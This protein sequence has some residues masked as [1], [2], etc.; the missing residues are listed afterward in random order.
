MKR[1]TAQCAFVFQRLY[2]VLSWGNESRNG[3]PM[4]FRSYGG[5]T[6]GTIYDDE[7]DF[8][9]AFA[10]KFPG[11]TDDTQNAAARLRR[12]LK[13]LADDG[14]LDRK[15]RPN[16]KEYLGEGGNWS[17]EYSLPQQLAMKIRDGKTTAEEM[18]RRYQGDSELLK[19][20]N[21]WYSGAQVSE[22]EGRR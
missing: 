17:Y 22:M 15:V 7:L 19:D 16:Y 3:G 21:R 1:R 12:L 18:A 14:W 4:V 10:E 2:D 13:Q 20:A 6:C 8:I 9:T 5:L 11:R